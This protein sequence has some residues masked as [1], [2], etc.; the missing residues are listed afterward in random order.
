MTMWTAALHIFTDPRMLPNPSASS[1]DHSGLVLNAVCKYQTQSPQ[2]TSQS[3]LTLSVKEANLFVE[4][5]DLLSLLGLYLPNLGVDLHIEGLQEALVDRHFLE[6]PREA[7]RAK[8][9]N[10]TKAT[11]SSK[12]TSH[13]SAT[14]EATSID[15]P[16]ATD[17]AAA[18]AP[19]APS[20]GATSHAD[21][22]ALVATRL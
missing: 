7:T 13:S 18:P 8:A 10:S 12:T 14:T 6:S 21:G 4:G 2:P 3:F 20:P 22:D 16:K 15:T 9:T 19:N 17:T 1:L 11:S 5:L